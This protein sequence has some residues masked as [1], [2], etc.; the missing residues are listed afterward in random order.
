MPRSLTVYGS[1]IRQVI[2]LENGEVRQEVAS[3]A[4]ACRRRMQHGHSWGE[5]EKLL[6]GSPS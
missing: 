3:Q 2:Q 5:T 4:V 1:S 6:Q